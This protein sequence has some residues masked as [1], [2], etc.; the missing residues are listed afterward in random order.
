MSS[1]VHAKWMNSATRAISGAPANRS[2]S[3]YSTALTS[4]FVVRSIALT[5]AASASA[6]SR[7]AASSAARASAPNGGH[8]G[9][10]RLVGECE[11]PRDL[12]PHAAADQCVFAEVVAQRVELVRIAA[13]ERR[14]RGERGFDGQVHAA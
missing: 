6:N 4:W 14:Q 8:F 2:F 1:D 12:D 7:P 10:R 3:Q 13:I 5:R 11:Q 9:D